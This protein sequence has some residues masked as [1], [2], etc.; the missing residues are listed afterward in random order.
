MVKIENQEIPDNKN[1]SIALTSIYGIG[2]HRAKEMVKECA[3]N[4]YTK[5]KNLTVEQIYNI[6][7]AIKK[8]ATGSELKQ[9]IKENIDTQIKIG[10]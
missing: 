1:I 4:P 9:Q 8:Y 5:A 10:S 3:I 2:R 6:I 7:L